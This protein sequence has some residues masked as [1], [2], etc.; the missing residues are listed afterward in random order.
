M[1]RK[2][3]NGVRET[4]QELSK[5]NCKEIRNNGIYLG[6][7]DRQEEGRKEGESMNQMRKRGNLV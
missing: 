2:G 1:G 4:I 5:S 6:K 3:L 7:K